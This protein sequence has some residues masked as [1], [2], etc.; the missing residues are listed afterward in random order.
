MA[1]EEV[2]FEQLSANIQQTLWSDVVGTLEKLKV[3]SKHLDNRYDISY[4]CLVRLKIL[5]F[6]LVFSTCIILKFEDICVP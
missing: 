4:R 6:V 5:D 2:L 1:D 3:W